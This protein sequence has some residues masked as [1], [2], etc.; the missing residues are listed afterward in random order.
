V[1][2]N[3]GFECEKGTAI[4]EEGPGAAS[5]DYADVVAGDSSHSVAVPGF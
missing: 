1:L 2:V 4:V 5:I 3:A